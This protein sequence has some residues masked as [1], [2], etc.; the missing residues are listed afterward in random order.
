ML[1]NVFKNQKPASSVLTLLIFA[2]FW[3]SDW[4]LHPVE[5]QLSG[6]MPLYMLLVEL[7]GDYLWVHQIV[8]GI[9]I[10]LAAISL[11]GAVNRQ[12]MF[13]SKNNL[14]LFFV[15]FLICCIPEVVNPSPA[16]WSL[17]FFALSIREL[18]KLYFD[19]GSLMI[20][21]NA[22]LFLSLSWLMYFPIIVFFPILWIAILI[23]GYTDWRHITAVVLG[24][25]TPPFIAFSVWVWIPG[26]VDLTSLNYWTALRTGQ[27]DLTIR[28]ANLPVMIA[29]LITAVT[30]TV[31]LTLNLGKKRVSNRKNFLLMIWVIIAAL[32]GF[33]VSPANQFT[34]LSVLALPMSLVMANL[35]YY[36]K[37]P[38]WTNLVMVAL[39][40]TALISVLVT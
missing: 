10:W 19:E 11:N 2:L 3:L 32:L 9:M 7:I 27:I 22:S 28:P 15:I 38:L 5:I 8:T 23:N 33:F 31:E 12:D 21:L 39:L 29:V 13:K 26:L 24:F 25:L 14:T 18:Y 34:H 30:G 35:F 4:F 17:P 20:A 40:A 1:I 36:L 37:K 6:G 16:L